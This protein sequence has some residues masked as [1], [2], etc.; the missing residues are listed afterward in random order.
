MKQPHCKCQLYKG[1]LNHW[2]C[3]KLIL[4]ISSPKFLKLHTLSNPNTLLPP[5]RVISRTW[6]NICPQAPPTC[7]CSPRGRRGRASSRSGGSCWG[8]PAWRR[9]R[10]RP[11]T[12]WGP[13]TGER[14]TMSTVCTAQTPPTLP[15]SECRILMYLYF[16]ANIC[17][18]TFCMIISL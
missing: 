9:P 18:S 5:S 3:H 13:S 4:K 7:W 6:S 1:I 14:R 8:R 16:R 15:W 2:E 17:V 11:P 12:A 10:G